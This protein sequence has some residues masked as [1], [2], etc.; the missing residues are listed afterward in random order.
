MATALAE[1]GGLRKAVAMRLGANDN[2]SMVEMTDAVMARFGQTDI[3]VNRIAAAP[4]IRPST[5]PLKSGAYSIHATISV[6]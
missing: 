5:S 2:Q 4:A 1:V 3:L 6:L